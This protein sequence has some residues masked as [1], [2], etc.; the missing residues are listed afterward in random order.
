MWGAL[1]V[2]SRMWGRE[3]N[4]RVRADT[5]TPSRTELPKKV[6]K[7]ITNFPRKKDAPCGARSTKRARIFIPGSRDR[8]AWMR[9]I[10]ANF[11]LPSGSLCSAFLSP[12]LVILGISPI[13]LQ[14]T[15][16][17]IRLFALVH[18]VLAFFSYS[19][20]S[21]V[22][23]ESSIS[24]KPS[25]ISAQR[26]CGCYWDSSSSRFNNSSSAVIAQRA[27]AFRNPPSGVSVFSDCQSST[28][29]LQRDKAKT[30]RISN[31]ECSASL[32]K[33]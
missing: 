13:W 3:T 31:R 32:C 12:A 29:Y 10:Q 25:H 16:F 22:T 20:I 28:F 6:R 33:L 26:F 17:F 9:R 24:S 23:R 27:L 4:L 8:N 11:A 19:R 14:P 7:R 5:N 1:C 21:R 18:S 15:T 2:S 30:F